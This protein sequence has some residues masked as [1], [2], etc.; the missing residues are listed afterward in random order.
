MGRRNALVIPCMEVQAFRCE[1]SESEYCK[2]V[3]LCKAFWPWKSGVFAFALYLRIVC[4]L[5]FGQLK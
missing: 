5:I 2:A 4:S 1:T 3:T